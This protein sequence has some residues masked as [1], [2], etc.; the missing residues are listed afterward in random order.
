MKYYCNHCEEY[1]SEKESKS[2]SKKYGLI[3]NISEKL[4]IVHVDSYETFCPYCET[5][6]N[7]ITECD[8][9]YYEDQLEDLEGDDDSDYEDSEWGY[10]DSMNLWYP[11][12]KGD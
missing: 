9:D 8:L 4:S 3:Q 11:N 12:G 5:R 2:V 6:G 10:Y 7:H 1:F